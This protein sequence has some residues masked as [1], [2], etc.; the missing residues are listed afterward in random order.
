MPELNHLQF[1]CDGRMSA[2]TF[3]ILTVD[4]SP[5]SIEHYKS[6]LH[7]DAE[8]LA[9][10]CTAKATCYCANIAAGFM[11]SQFTHWLR[12]FPLLYPEIICNILA[13]ELT[14]AGPRP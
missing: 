12:A 13:A 2:E 4:K 3:R 1:F 10:S 14:V 6:T 11:L 8:A 9:E 5:A 7:T